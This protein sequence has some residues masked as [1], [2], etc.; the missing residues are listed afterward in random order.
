MY[1]NVRIFVSV[2]HIVLDVCVCVRVCAYGLVD[3]QVHFARMWDKTTKFK[4]IIVV[5]LERS[6]VGISTQFQLNNESG[7]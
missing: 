4:F 3:P 2:Q 7:W 6:S 5:E 1:E